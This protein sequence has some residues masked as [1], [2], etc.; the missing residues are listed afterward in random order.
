MKLSLLF[1]AMSLILPINLFAGA[2]IKLETVGKNKNINMYLENNKLKIEMKEPG[3]SNSVIYRKDQKIINVVDYQKKSYVEL[4]EDQIKSV[5]K[6]ISPMMAQLKEMMKKMPPA[7]RKMMEKRMGGMMA[8]GDKKKPKISLK[9]VASGV[10]VGKYKTDHY[11]V[12]K[13][14]KVISEFWSAKYKV[15]GLRKSDLNILK[16]MNAFFKPLTDM[17]SQYGGQMNKNGLNFQQWTKLNGFPVKTFDHES[18]EV[19]LLKIAKRQSHKSKTFNVP[20]GFKIN[21]MPKG[22]GPLK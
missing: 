3:R 19:T 13:G 14:K 4:S 22:M 12:F 10:K 21:R 17:A 2:Y 20:E 8:F 1:F 16:E 6:M 7:Q 11:K 5:G 15:L 9:K 18:N